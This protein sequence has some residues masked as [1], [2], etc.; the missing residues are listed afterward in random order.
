MNCASQLRHGSAAS[1]DGVALVGVILLKQR[2]LA[3]DADVEDVVTAKKVCRKLRL[4]TLLDDL[5]SDALQVRLLVQDRQ[6]V[7]TWKCLRNF[8]ESEIFFLPT[9]NFNER[10]NSQPTILH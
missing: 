7:E 6:S 9:R 10:N 2:V 3:L 5:S 1:V 4:P 8:D